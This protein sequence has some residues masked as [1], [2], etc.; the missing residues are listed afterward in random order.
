MNYKET[1]EEMGLKQADV[2]RALGLSGALVSQVMASKYQGDPAVEGR[3]QSYLKQLKKDQRHT[4]LKPIHIE[5][6][7]LGY[8]RTT[9]DFC[10]YAGVMGT[11]IGDPG[12]GKSYAL[13]EI[14][15]DRKEALLLEC[16]PNMGYG[17]LL[18]HLCDL[19]GVTRHRTNSVT[20]RAVYDYFRKHRRVLLIDEGEQLQKEGL[21]GL[22]RL[23]DKTQTP[24]ILAGTHELGDRLKGGGCR[25]YAQLYSRI[26]GH[27]EFEG[28]SDAVCR[29]ACEQLGIE[30]AGEVIALL[31]ERC[32]NEKN[33]PR[34]RYLTHTLAALHFFAFRTG[35]PLSEV[36][37]AAVQQFSIFN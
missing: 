28:A 36:N 33:P 12:T 1:L 20:A 29:Q 30:K 11:L 25:E 5:T 23:W 22:R 34:W 8:A 15:K 14:L 27:V 19:T 26:A 7:D 16:D 9:V 10:I 21:E 32:R 2:A 13:G 17:D 4:K 6:Q 35:K 37:I 18:T 31:K 3:I 24:I